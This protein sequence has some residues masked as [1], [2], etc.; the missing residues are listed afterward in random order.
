MQMEQINKTPSVNIELIR[1]R[2]SEKPRLRKLLELMYSRRR[3]RLEVTFRRI[4]RVM[5]E[6]DASPW[7]PDE[8]KEY[9]QVL[10]AAGAGRIV[11]GANTPRF[12]FNYHLQSLASAIL[13]LPEMERLK[14]DG[15]PMETTEGLRKLSPP[16]HALPK[17]SSVPALASP[18]T[19][20]PIKHKL[21]EPV[22]T[23]EMI[24]LRR[25][26]VELEVDLAEVTPAGCRKITELLLGLNGN[27]K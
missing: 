19:I 20:T 23:R 25:N 6:Q 8:I 22:K 9:M 24:K 14:R 1:N 27:S 17:L 18:T 21:T 13:G 26:G 4:K 5:D 16:R 10:E 12:L 11:Y 3:G 2:M 7:S 15:T